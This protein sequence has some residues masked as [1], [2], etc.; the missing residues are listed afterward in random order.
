MNGLWIQI[1]HTGG[2]QQQHRSLHFL[3]QRRP[4]R[5]LLWRWIPFLQPVD[6][7][8]G[9]NQCV[10]CGAETAVIFDDAFCQPVG[11]PLT[12]YGIMIDRPSLLAIA[13]FYPARRK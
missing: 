8:S 10:D 12:F 7:K 11:L 2:N 5:D 6:A 1:H 13:F 3:R 4:C 9:L